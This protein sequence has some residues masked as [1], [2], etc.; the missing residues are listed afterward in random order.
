MTISGVST[1]EQEEAILWKKEAKGADT[2]LVDLIGLI[3][4]SKHLVVE[5]SVD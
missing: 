5:V 1:E 4:S 3:V 2:K